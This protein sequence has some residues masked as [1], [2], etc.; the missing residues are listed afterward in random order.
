MDAPTWISAI[1]AV[2]AVVA[3]IVGVLLTTK[4]EK[5]ANDA[6]NKAI[7]SADQMVAAQARIAASLEEGRQQATKLIPNWEIIHRSGMSYSLKNCCEEDAINVVVE[8]DSLRLPR[9]EKDLL[10]AG[11]SMEICGA[12]S[13]GSSAIARV[14]WNRPPEKNDSTEYLWEGV[15]PN[16]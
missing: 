5:E 11:S 16:H 2:I 3:T 13:M 4:H 7:E 6:A 12:F 15:F 1:S 14:T 9:V 10:P 8:T